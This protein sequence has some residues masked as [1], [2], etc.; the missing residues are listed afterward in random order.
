MAITGQPQNQ[1]AN[2]LQFLQL[3]AARGSSAGTGSGSDGAPGGPSAVEGGGGRGETDD[4]PLLS[5]VMPSSPRHTQL[6]LS[7]LQHL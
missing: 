2:Q 6:S 7:P 1:S 4:A 3:I 5:S